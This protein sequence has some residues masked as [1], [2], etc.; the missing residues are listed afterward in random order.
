MNCE[1]LQDR[2]DYTHA[3]YEMG[4]MGRFLSIDPVVDEKFSLGNP[5]AWNRYV[6][7]RNNPTG[8]IDPNGKDPLDPK[9]LLFYNRILRGNFSRVDV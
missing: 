5:Q 4:T 7:V 9:L 8:L 2:I 3:R 6:Y 1:A